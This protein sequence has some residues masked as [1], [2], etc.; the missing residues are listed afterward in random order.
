MDRATL[1]AKVGNIY[2][3]A[4]AVMFPID[5]LWC[6]S[7]EENICPTKYTE[8]ELEAI[9]RALEATAELTELLQNL[10]KELTNGK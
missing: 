3:A 5:D 2:R 6:L 8:S 10:K 7:A 1:R 4:E 9:G